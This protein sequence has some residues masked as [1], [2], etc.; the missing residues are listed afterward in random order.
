LYAALT[1]LELGEYN[2]LRPHH[3]LPTNLQELTA[4]NVTSA[5][6]LLPLK[7]LRELTL[8]QIEH[9]AAP[10]EELLQLTTLTAL[11]S[12][13]L[14]YWADTESID[15]VAGGWGALKVTA[16][17]VVPNDA[18]FLARETLLQLASL[19]DIGTLGLGECGLAELEPELLAGALGEMHKLCHLTLCDV[20]WGLPASDAV[21]ASALAELLQGL[22]GR[23]RAM[24]RLTRLHLERQAVGRAAAAALSQMNG[25]QKLQ[26]LDCQLEDCSVIE[27]AL[28]LKPWLLQLDVSS[29]PLLTDAC[30]PALVYAVPWPGLQES[31]LCGCTGMTR[32][33]LRR[34]VH[35]VDSASDSDSDSGSD[36]DSE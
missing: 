17:Q 16:L 29:N 20:Y 21:N 35:M 5:A 2:T 12:V 1:K 32:T 31:S 19:T 13:D 23:R 8:R 33:G 25:L 18:R 34:Y 11:T 7:Q 22:A 9:E 36:S 4:G 28:G 3:L 27:I 26:L 10:A 6:C 24:H 14:T 15:A 30:L